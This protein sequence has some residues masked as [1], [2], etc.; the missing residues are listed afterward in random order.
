MGFH[1]ST[2]VVEFA[3]AVVAAV[4]LG[5]VARAGRRVRRSANK[6]K[7]GSALNRFLRELV[8]A[9]KPNRPRTKK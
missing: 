6:A 7:L 5:I 8:G 9:S 3:F 1:L 2:F 4:A